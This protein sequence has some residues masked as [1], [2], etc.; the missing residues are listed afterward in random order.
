MMRYNEIR[1]E[2]YTAVLDV[3]Q[4]FAGMFACSDHAVRYRPSLSTD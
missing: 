4:K 1:N 3:L 2:E